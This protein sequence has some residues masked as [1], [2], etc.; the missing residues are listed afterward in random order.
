MADAL[1][2]L[3]WHAAA[4][5]AEGDPANEILAASRGWHADLIVTGSRGI[6]TDS[7]AAAGQRRP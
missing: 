3:G 6:G 1:M 2:D 5:V 4:I 7:A